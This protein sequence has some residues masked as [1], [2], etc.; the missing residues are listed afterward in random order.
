MTDR[1]G[2]TAA[3][4]R[5]RLNLLRLG[6]L[7]IAGGLGLVIWPQILSPDTVWSHNGGTVTAMLGAMGL[8]AL[9]GLWRPLEMLPL[10]LFEV[11]WKA[12]WLTRIALPAWQAGTLDPATRQSA[13]E[14]L[15]I[16]PFLVL[17]PWDQVWHRIFRAQA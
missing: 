2:S 14:C 15:L 6:Y 17:I 11:T 1:P 12:L 3:L 10:L 13:F 4:P 16:V 8:L 9:I 7:I 5:W